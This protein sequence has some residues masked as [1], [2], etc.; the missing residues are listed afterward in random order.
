MTRMS[1]V[2]VCVA[3]L[4]VAV[5]SGVAMGRQASSASEKEVL[6]AMNALTAA[7][8]KKDKAALERG[9]AEDYVYHG[10]NGRVISSKAQSIAE[11][12]SA[13][14]QWTSR[15]YEN[16]KVRVYGDV[17]II[18]GQVTLAGTSKSYR[19]GLRNITGLWVK[20]D[21]RWQNLGGQSTLV[22]TK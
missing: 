3:A 9:Y 5:L 17:A 13:D 20:R 11:D 19:T 2:T 15:K 10:S 8:D 4:I 14:T 6:Q 18:T 16:L 22:P 12:L 7:A 1:R 21:G